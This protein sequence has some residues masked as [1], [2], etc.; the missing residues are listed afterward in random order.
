MSNSHNSAW[1]SNQILPAVELD[2]PNFQ[3]IATSG[4]TKETKDYK[5][6]TIENL[7]KFSFHSSLNS[8]YS[9]K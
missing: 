5:T 6:I 2:A 4:T 7:K 8:F 1:M 9:D 3:F